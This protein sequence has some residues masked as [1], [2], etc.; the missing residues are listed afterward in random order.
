ME[1]Q[2]ELQSDLANFD[3]VSKPADGHPPTMPIG[4]DF[5]RVVK[6]KLSF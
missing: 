5:H 1:V 6:C 4:E 2:D 3:S